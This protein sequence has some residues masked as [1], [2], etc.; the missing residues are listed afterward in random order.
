MYQYVRTIPTLLTTDVLVVGAGSAG[1]LAAIAAARQGR[2]VTLIERYGFLG[3]VSTGVLDTFYGFYTPGSESRRVV[4]GIPGEVIA[5]LKDHNAAFE[6]PN[7]FG[8]GTGVT[9]HPRHVAR[10]LRRA[11]WT[12]LPVGAF[13][14]H[15]FRA[16]PHQDPDGNLLLFRAAPSRL[17]ETR[18]EH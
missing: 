15:A 9:Y 12:V 5:R 7:T 13:A 11:G 4:D 17:R 18:R 14:S 10:V 1:C 6:R 3:G 2:S 8:A 16:I